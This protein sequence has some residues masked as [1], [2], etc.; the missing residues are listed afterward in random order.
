MKNSAR[1][2]KIVLNLV[3]LAASFAA[4]WAQERLIVIGGGRRPPESIARFTEWAGA[5]KARILIVTWASGVPGESFEAIK[6]DFD[7]ERLAAFENAPLAPLDAAGRERFLVQLEAA[8]G[9]FFTGGDQN[10]IMDV[11][12]DETLY[13]ALREKYRGG[14]VFGGTSAGAAVLSDP[15]MTG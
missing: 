12:R 15:M 5:E 3:L 10:R 2:A 1:L 8:T 6:N 11:L 14:A 13:R 4:G 9:V 7:A